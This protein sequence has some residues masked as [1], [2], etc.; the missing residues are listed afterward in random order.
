MKR[1]DWQNNLG[2]AYSDRIRGEEAEN[3]EQAIAAHTAALTV[4]TQLL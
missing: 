4:Y 1:K 3:L 2:S